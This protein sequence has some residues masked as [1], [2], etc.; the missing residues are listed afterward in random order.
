M[1]SRAKG[2]VPDPDDHQV[3]SFRHAKL[4]ALKA[5]ALPDEVDLRPHAPPVLDQNDTSSCVGHAIACAVGTSFS[6]RG[7]PLG[8]TPSPRGLY[9]LARCIDRADP[10]IPLVDEGS[11]PNQAVRSLSEWGIHAMQAPSPQGYDSDCDPS[12]VNNEPTL[13]ELEQDALTLVVGQYEIDTWGPQ[14]VLDICTALAAGYAVT[15][16][17]SA[18]NATWQQWTP[19]NDPLGAQSPIK[20]DHYVW[21]IGYRTVN[22]KKILRIRNQWGKL[23]GDEGEIEVTEDFVDQTS[24]LYA[25]NVRRAA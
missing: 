2:Y 17:V 12:N 18:G 11:M 10:S 25:Y 20:L 1:I 19:A 4:G 5:V 9:C 16:S 22:G 8:F 6:F 23:W 21:F 3:T 14:R 15:C 7:E 13:L 24:D